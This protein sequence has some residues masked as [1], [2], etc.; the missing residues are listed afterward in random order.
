MFERFGEFDSVEELNRAADAQRK[1]GDIEA[2]KAIASENGIDEDEVLD[3]VDEL[4]S[5]LATPLM[6][7]LG[8]LKVESE[9]AKLAGVLDDW[10]VAAENE[11]LLMIEKTEGD[12]D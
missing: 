3:F 11:K 9:D 12:Y 2:I 6:A 10:Y 4:S 5:E 1:E 7:A 8:K